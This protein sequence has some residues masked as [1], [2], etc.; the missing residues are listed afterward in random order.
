MKHTCVLIFLPIY[1][2]FTQN[3]H[4]IAIGHFHKMFYKDLYFSNKN[5]LFGEH[6]AK[7]MEMHINSFIQKI[8]LEEY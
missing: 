8:G 3:Y 7:E 6:N 1:I 2:L 5:V 4:K